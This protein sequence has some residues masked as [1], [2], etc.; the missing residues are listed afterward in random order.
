MQLSSNIVNKFGNSISDKR[1]GYKVSR[2]YSG[3]PL[4][5]NAINAR[6]YAV[7]GDCPGVPT[8]DCPKAKDADSSP[9]TFRTEYFGVH[10]FLILGNTD[11]TKFTISATAQ[12]DT[13]NSAGKRTDTQTAL[14]SIDFAFYTNAMDNGYVLVYAPYRIDSNRNKIDAGEAGKP[15]P[16]EPLMY[17]EERAADRTYRVIPVLKNLPAGSPL[18]TDAQMEFQVYMGGGS[19]ETAIQTPDEEGKFRTNFILGETPGRNRILAVGSVTAD[20]PSYDAQGNETRTSKKLTGSFPIEL[21]GIKTNVPRAKQVI[22]NSSGYTM[23]DVDLTYLPEPPEYKYTPANIGL[24]VYEKTPTGSEVFFGYLPMDSNN[25]IILSMGT[26]KLDSANSYYGKVVVN[27]GTAAVRSEKIALVN[28]ALI[29]DYDRNGVIDDSDRERVAAGDK[30]Y[31]WINDDD[32]EGETDGSDIPGDKMLTSI[33]LDHENTQVD[34]IRDLIDLFPVYIDIKSV[35]KAFDPANHKY[36]LKSEDAS[37]NFVFTDLEAQHSGYYLTGD[38]TNLNIPVKLGSADTFP[39]TSIGTEL[40]NTLTSPS[41]LDSIA[42][43]TA[44]S[45]KGII[46]LE[47]KKESIAPLEF[48]VLDANQKMVFSMKLNLNMAGVEKMF[49]HKNL[50]PVIYTAEAPGPGTKAGEEDRLDDRL[51]CPDVACLGA[52]PQNLKNFV[53]LHGYNVNGQEA[54]GWQSEM[55]KR[56]FWSGSR[57]R[58]WG[59]TWYGWDT[60]IPVIDKTL[61]FYGN[62]VHAFETA[63]KLD[64]F[65]R[66][67]VMAGKKIIAAHSLGN[68]V[69]SGTI[70]DYT[71]PVDKYFLFNAAVA[72]E[73]FDETEVLKEEAKPDLIPSAWSDYAT[74]LRASEWY[75]LFK[76]QNPSDERAKLTWRNRFANVK[77]VAAYNFYSEGDEVVSDWWQRA[78]RWKG[79]IPLYSPY[80]GWEFNTE[81]D[82]YNPILSKYVRMSASDANLI[83]P[84]ELKTK[85]FFNR[86]GLIAD[87]LPPGIAGS[88]AAIEK[89]DELLARAFPAT[90]W[91][92]G[93]EKTKAIAPTRNTNMQSNEGMTTKT[94][95]TNTTTYWPAKRKE[96]WLHSDIKDVAYPYLFKIYDNIICAGEI[97]TCKAK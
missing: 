30:F 51:N 4:P 17:Y 11:S 76:D 79:T 36:I 96:Q 83:T 21:W 62:V 50:T 84:S 65:L 15:M 5:A 35:L 6:L 69:V 32:D 64:E 23:A 86:G 48:A 52:D 54:R 34:G 85:P 27:R 16:I 49:R 91:A 24:E 56:M 71:A 20:V 82:V 55:F 63:P 72:L 43:S 61:S 95:G 1:V 31:F 8:L 25:K 19:P 88:N 77:N 78:E 73:A 39:I 89:R 12:K 97:G 7:E 41:F 93:R 92:T 87:I 90:T 29:P 46:L 94:I 40:I 42:S 58:F 45:S 75:K 74:Q 53:F 9:L 67:D 80:G 47:G 59:V 2:T 26:A 14:S 44:K 28:T 60:Q 66:S 57:A 3:T 13:I 38:D 81:W 18:H 10:P 70:S 37:L 68:M 33:N 22:Q